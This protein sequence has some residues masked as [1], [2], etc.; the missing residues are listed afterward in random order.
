MEFIQKLPVILT[1]GMTLIIAITS[2]ISGVDTQSI[3]IRICFS[4]AGFLTVG[5]LTRRILFG[6]IDE[7]EAK[8]QKEE[9]E[10][11]LEEAARKKAEKE[12]AAQELEQSQTGSQIDYRINEDMDDFSPLEV[13]KVIKTKIQ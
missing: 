3:Y 9:R 5:L 6:I 12:A 11:M 1:I 10:K 2:Y 4:L 8:K 7:L 13:S